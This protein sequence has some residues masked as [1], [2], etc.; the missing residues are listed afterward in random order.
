MDENYDKYKDDIRLAE[1][2]DYTA[3]GL[4]I[5]GIA[6]GVVSLYFFL[7][8]EDPHRYERYRSL[9]GESKNQSSSGGLAPSLS[10]GTYGIS[11]EF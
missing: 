2:L 5:A 4:G 8:G 6:A 9:E 1:V 7:E 10:G 11:W 3:L